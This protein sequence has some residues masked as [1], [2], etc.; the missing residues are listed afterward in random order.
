[1]TVTL[2]SQSLSS[3]KGG[4]LVRA[5]SLS[6][7]DLKEKTG[8]AP[9]TGFGRCVADVTFVDILQGTP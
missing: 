2:E 8:T 5:A 3:A 9:S 1:V 6:A 7:S 4:A